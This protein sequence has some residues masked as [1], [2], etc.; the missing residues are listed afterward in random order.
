MKVEVLSH[1]KTHTKTTRHHFEF[2]TILMKIRI[3]FEDDLI[4]HGK[5]NSIRCI[6]YL[7]RHT[8]KI[9]NMKI[10]SSYKCYCSNTYENAYTSQRQPDYKPQKNQVDTYHNYDIKKKRKYCNQVFKLLVWKL[11][12]NVYVSKTILLHTEINFKSNS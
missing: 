1:D 10:R 11:W 6:E 8:I 7:W 3:C 4:T 12:K 2:F 9:W 5:K